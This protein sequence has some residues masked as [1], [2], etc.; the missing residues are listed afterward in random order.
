MKTVSKPQVIFKQTALAVALTLG[1]GA[2][3]AAADLTSLEVSGDTLTWTPADG[4]A[5]TLSITGDA[6][7]VYS[8]SSD[9]TVS[10]AFDATGL[11]DGLYSYI[12]SETVGVD[13]A[14]LKARAKT[15]ESVGANAD[16]HTGESQSGYFS[17]SGGSLIDPTQ[18]EASPGKVVLTNAD[19]VIRNS[20]CV[21]FDC[22]NSPS[23]SDTTVLL[24][25]NNTRIKFDDTSSINSFPRNDWEIEA[26]SN[27]NGGASYLGF[28][29]CGQSSQGGCAADLVFA[30]EAGARQHALYVESDG[31]VGIGTSNPV[32]R[33]HAID[34][35]TP[36]LRLEQDGSS[37]FA[38]QTWDVAGNETSFFVRDA[39]N[40]STLPFRIRPGAASNRLVI[41]SDDDVGIGTLSP[42]SPLHVVET[43]AGDLTMLHLTNNG[44]PRIQMTNSAN[45]AVDWV[46]SAVGAGFRISDV[47]DSD[48]EFQLDNSGNLTIS[49]GLTTAMN[50]L[51]DYVF[52]PDYPLMPLTD[53]AA[54]IE[55]NKHLP[56]IPSAKEV[57]RTGRIDMTELQRRL[58][59]K[60]EELTLYTLDQQRT[61]SVQE[62][63]IAAQ[64]EAIGRLSNRLATLEKALQARLD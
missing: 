7:V 45:A 20:T 6:G 37:G 54:F 46:F 57:A 5:V 1:L 22:P 13:L 60:V 27:L 36:A 44:N 10:L 43:A 30:V 12:V 29:D 39:T 28:N 49:G 19:G 55:R 51:P 31:D 52:E 3:L 58:L 23:F 8:D 14:G 33:V 16:N 53:L 59:E 25:E 40:G 42:D 48:N 24:M 32:V 38:P 63:T 17:V 47:G 2:S 9:G 34:G 35:D 62:S 15:R 50:S 64:H 41:D 61:I 56:N 26:N 11:P 21:G 4:H 18:V